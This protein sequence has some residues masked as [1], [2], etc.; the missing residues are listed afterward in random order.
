MK[1]MLLWASLA[2][3]GLAFAQPLPSSA[4]LLT[5]LGAPIEMAIVPVD[6]SGVALVSSSK[7]Y[8]DPF[9]GQQDV[10]FG[11]VVH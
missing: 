5:S 3:A 7:W 8:R 1:K 10:G 9:C 11:I 6:T 4:A 2:V